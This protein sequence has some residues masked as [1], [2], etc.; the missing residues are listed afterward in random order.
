[1]PRGAKF[2]RTDSEEGQ[3]TEGDAGTDSLSG[4]LLSLSNPEGRRFNSFPI[5]PLK[6]H[7][8]EEGRIEQETRRG[9]RSLGPDGRG[10]QYRENLWD[11]HQGPTVPLECQGACRHSVG[12]DWGSGAAASSRNRSGSLSTRSNSN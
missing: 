12:E 6:V 7:R 5:P 1:R 2:G 9:N 11:D 3:P 4:R 10:S 8:R